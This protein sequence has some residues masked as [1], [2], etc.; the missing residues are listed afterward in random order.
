M[1]LSYLLFPPA[2]FL[3]KADITEGSVCDKCKETLLSKISPKQKAFDVDGV[4]VEG[5][6]IFDYNDKDVQALLF[7]LKK[8]GDRDLLRFAAE[9]YK[10]AVPKN[11]CGIVTGVPRRRMNVRFYGYDHVKE[12]I[13][14]MCGKNENLS[15][16]MLLVR[17]GFSLEQKKLSAKRRMVNASGKF[18]AAKKD[19]QKNILIVDDVT[20]TGS[21]IVSCAKE[22]LKANPKAKLH[23]AFLAAKT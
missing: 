16:E 18:S 7:A 6:Y 1:N 23:F 11:F 3:C 22:I 12:P 15:F 9:L 20:T 4:K 14:I 21:T 5:T 19:I 13:K 8:D 17:K 10:Y 2:C